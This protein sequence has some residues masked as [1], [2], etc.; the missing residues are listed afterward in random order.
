MNPTEQSQS[1]KPPSEGLSPPSGPSIIPSL[2][3]NIPLPIGSVEL[4][5]IAGRFRMNRRG[6]YDPRNSNNFNPTNYFQ[7][8]YTNSNRGFRGRGFYSHDN[9]HYSGM[10]N[11]NPTVFEMYDA[12]MYDQNLN[13][14]QMNSNQHFSLNQCSNYV[15]QTSAHASGSQVPARFSASVTSAANVSPL[16]APLVVA[17]V[18]GG[19]FPIQ[20]MPPATTSMS[21][22]TTL[23]QAAPV[24]IE[25]IYVATA[26]QA[27]GSNQIQPDHQKAI[28]D[29][30]KQL[31]GCSVSNHRVGKSSTEPRVSPWPTRRQ[32]V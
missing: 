12:N 8:N 10:N 23:T 18:V 11:N 24:R 19:G 30:N 14:G 20:A 22:A 32:S 27:T 26:N 17:S 25:S 7:G 28:E 13:A 15:A 5:L 4:S 29:L 21:T 6:N 1:V 31:A 2:G 3:P 9:N 16:N